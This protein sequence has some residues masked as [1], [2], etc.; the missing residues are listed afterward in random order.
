MSKEFYS[1][2]SE[3]FFFDTSHIKSIRGLQANPHQ[4]F[5]APQVIQKKEESPKRKRK[6]EFHMGFANLE[7]R[8]SIEAI[9]GPTFSHTYN[10]SSTK[11]TS[12]LHGP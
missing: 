4:I 1:C 10:Q 9:G 3:F 5:Q 11:H 12:F 7:A 6:K 2:N 8:F